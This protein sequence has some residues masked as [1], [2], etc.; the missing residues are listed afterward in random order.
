M[1][2]HKGLPEGQKRKTVRKA[3]PEG[4]KRFLAKK[5]TKAANPNLRPGTKQSRK[6][7]IKKVMEKT[8]RKPAR[9]KR[10]S[11]EESAKRRDAILKEK[12]REGKKPK[13]N[14]PMLKRGGKV[15]KK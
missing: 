9:P 6:N 4:L 10:M 14:M 1:P 8:P 5:K 7:L 13:S 15:K 12:L 11:P 2:G 3:L